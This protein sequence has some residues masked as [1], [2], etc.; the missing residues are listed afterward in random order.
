MQAAAEGRGDAGADLQRRIFRPQG[1]S[2]ADGQ[3]RRDELAN[4]STEGNVAVIDVE[5]GFGLIDPAPPR[6]REDMNDQHRDDQAREARRQQHP[7]WREG[8]IPIPADR[9][10]TTQWRSGSRPWRVAEKTPMNTDRIRKKY[11][12]RKADRKRSSRSALQ[13]AEP[14]SGE[15]GEMSTLVPFMQF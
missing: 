7:H 8:V 4:G 1:V 5:R 2:R 13:R 14:R 3:R 12:S 10:G 6:P 11:S 9:C 15:L